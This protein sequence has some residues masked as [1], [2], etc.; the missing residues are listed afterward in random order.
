[1]S[2]SKQPSLRRHFIA[3]DSLRC[4]FLKLHLICLPRKNISETRSNENKKNFFSCKSGESC[5]FKN[6]PY[7]VTYVKPILTQES[8]SNRE[9]PILKTESKV[10]HINKEGTLLRRTC[11]FGRSCFSL[12]LLKMC[13]NVI[14]ETKGMEKIVKL[15]MKA[16][17]K[18]K[19][20]LRLVVVV[21]FLCIPKKT[22]KMILSWLC[23]KYRCSRSE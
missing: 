18:L 8:S 2:Q 23:E 9:K 22:G 13:V 20:S 14:I 19:F 17:L 11:F 7:W 6:Y 5:A 4:T 3:D 1:M 10:L 21:A 16:K 12:V 15:T